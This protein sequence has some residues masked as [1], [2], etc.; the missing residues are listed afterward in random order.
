[1]VEISQNIDRQRKETK[2]FN[3]LGDTYSVY[4]H[5][6]VYIYIFIAPLWRDSI[7]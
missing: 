1:M 6:Y 2:C 7:C 5:R 3:C 4:E